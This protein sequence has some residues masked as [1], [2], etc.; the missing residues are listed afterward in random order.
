MNKT[1]LLQIACSDG[2]GEIGLQICKWFR[3]GVSAAAWARLCSPRQGAAAWA[4]GLLPG[5]GV[6]PKPYVFHHPPTVSH[7]QDLRRA[8]Q[9][10]DHVFHRSFSVFSKGAFPSSHFVL[11]E[12][13]V[14]G[15]L[16]LEKDSWELWKVCLSSCIW[17]D[18]QMQSWH[19]SSL[20]I[21]IYL[22]KEEATPK[23]IQ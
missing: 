22:A 19:E 21:Y 11:E 4:V 9:R 13:A 10:S 17:S 15:E 3:P 14:N 23:V 16:D 5:N 2:D 6:C 8:A 12:L 20:Y 7:Q 18:E 1:N